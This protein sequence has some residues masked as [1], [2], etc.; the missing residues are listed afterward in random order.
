[1]LENVIKC[2][3]F[4]YTQEQRYTKVIYY[5]YF[6]LDDLAQGHLRTSKLS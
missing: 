5:Y 4:V 6:W 2:S 3:E 1:M